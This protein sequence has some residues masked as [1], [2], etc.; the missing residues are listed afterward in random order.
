MVY[1]RKYR[2]ITNGIESQKTECCECYTFLRKTITMK[3]CVAQTRPVTGDIEQNILRHKEFINH[4]T[5][6]GVDMIIFPELSLTGYEPTLAKALAVDLHDSRLDDFQSISNAQKITIGAGIP[7]K[8]EEGIT[9]SMI[10]FQPHRE[11]LVYAKKY[12]HPDEE[13][14]FIP[15]KNFPVM[16]IAGNTT[17]LA[18]CYELSV[19]A[20]A[21]EAFK[22][23]ASI[24]IASVAKF[25][26]GVDKATQRL[27]EIAQTKNAW[28]L[29]SN[30]IGPADGGICAGK[31][32][33]W[34]KEGTPLAQLNETNEGILNPRHPNPNLHS[35]APIA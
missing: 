11:R 27:A 26:S 13:P 6:P 9:I 3:I 24:Y 1:Y 16:T 7:L 32:A 2:N 29:M 15:G 35:P 20:H 10:I 23:G 34:N 4:A 18:I 21:D 17:A 14:F 19:P 33:A 8:T 5:S 25:T 28:V 12:I 31:T 30:A 22:N